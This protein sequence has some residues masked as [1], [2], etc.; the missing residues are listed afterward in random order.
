MNEN[1]KA[2]RDALRSCV[3]TDE[4]NQELEKKDKLLSEFREKFPRE[5][6]A[7][8]LTLDSYCAGEGNKSSFCYWVLLGTRGIASCQSIAPS[9]DNLGVVRKNDG[10]SWSGNLNANSVKANLFDPLVA[11]IN[12]KGMNRE[13]K[14]LNRKIRR[15]FLMKILIL[16]FYDE[17]VPLISNSQ[18]KKICNAFGI[19]VSGEYWEVNRR[20][21]E[22]VDG[23]L[24]AEGLYPMHPSLIYG[25]LNQVVGFDFDNQKNE[26]CFES[27]MNQGG[28]EKKN[29]EI[30]ELL[31]SARQVILTGA[32]GT[33]KTYLAKKVAMAM[34]GKDY[35]QENWAEAFKAG[36]VGFCQF[37]PSYDYSDFVEGLRP[38]TVGN[39]E[40]AQV[41]FK[42]M[43]GVFKAFCKNALNGGARNW[44]DDFEK[45]W[46]LLVSRI[47]EGPE[48]GL[49]IPLISGRG[50]FAL[51]LNVSGSGLA[52]QKYKDKVG[53]KDWISGTV[54]FFSRE[55]LY[56]VFRGLSGVPSGGH[57]SYRK[58]IVDYMKKECGLVEYVKDNTDK[59]SDAA[60]P[61]V[62]IIDEINRG[63][64]SKI[65]GELFFSIDPG[66]R[67]KKGLVKTQYQNLV[68][69]RDEFE[70]GFYVP[71]NV[72]II[73]TMNDID[74]SVESM[75][76][77]IRRRFVWKEV[78]ADPEVLDSNDARKEI[79]DDRVR[80]KA[81]S[82][83]KALNNEVVEELG[84]EY[85][86]GPAYFFKLPKLQNDFSKL[87]D[88][89]LKPLLREYLR[90]NSKD[91]ITAK[92]KKFE[93]AYFESL[94][95]TQK[96][97]DKLNAADQNGKDASGVSA[98]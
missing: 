13:V 63:D 50:S 44:N 97:D 14:E 90:G 22:F 66:Y 89:N 95:E 98:G 82:L 87:W 67:G 56:N 59:Q 18:Y 7:S 46:K 70:N 10:F 60:S 41:G 91:E 74:R 86:I 5:K 19:A 3:V 57:D 68:E 83:M 39:G 61:Y 4:M 15:D 54:K 80:E 65:F 84:S 48:F 24:R 45:A 53:D 52:S 64:I 72:Y 88:M 32:P 31:E 51:T 8:L 55:Q 20:I 93:N 47:D 35:T 92:M 6:L 73:G 77:A 96:R 21:K 85:A 26:Q 29:M 71:T 75:D 81:T 42:R 40:N 30:C 78:P 16:Y 27:D 17:Y 79:P 49:E 34:L 94:P 69:P 12:S 37:H 1:I 62:F 11:F 76:F 36:R 9:S 2:L 25:A 38:V 23:Q 58:A 28:E 43:D 33:G